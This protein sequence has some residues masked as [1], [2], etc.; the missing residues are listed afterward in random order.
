MLGGVANLCGFVAINMMSD[1]ILPVL[2]MAAPVL[3]VAAL[4]LLSGRSL[5]GSCGGIGSDG[6]CSRCGK[7]AAGASGNARGEGVG[8]ACM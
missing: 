4:A 3:I 6:K 8:D 2:A 1:L 7:S 5:S